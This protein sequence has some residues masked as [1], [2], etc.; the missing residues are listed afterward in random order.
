MNKFRIVFIIS[1]LMLSLLHCTSRSLRVSD[2]AFKAHVKKIVVLPVYLSEA[3]IPPLPEQLKEMDFD[4]SERELF[5]KKV[6]D[7]AVYFAKSADEILQKGKFALET[8][9]LPPKECAEVFKDVRV[10][11]E[12]LVIDRER[13]WPLNLVYGLEPQA[14]TGLLEKY[15]ADAVLFHYFQSN[16]RLRT[17]S[18]SGYRVT[19]Y[20]TLPHW[21]LEY[22]SI[23]YGKSGKVLFD[24]TMRCFQ[25]ETEQSIGNQMHR[26]VKL[27]VIQMNWYLIDEVNLKKE[28][29]QKRGSFYRDFVKI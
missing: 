9:Y 29:Y 24:K 6:K 25:M 11:I 21:Y 17:Y 14:V 13:K 18:W 5:Y 8:V 2:A 16:K 12:P 20:V 23:I 22:T 28:L 1:V 10:R 27:P 15:K 3:L 26:S 7:Y 4:K 19:Y